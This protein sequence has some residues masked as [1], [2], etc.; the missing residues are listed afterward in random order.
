M[1]ERLIKEEAILNRFIRINEYAESEYTES[2]N[3]LI[4]TSSES[5]SYRLN[6][7]DY[8]RENKVVFYTLDF[9]IKN[10]DKI[11]DLIVQNIYIVKT[12]EGCPYL[13]RGELK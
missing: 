8:V 11:N 5:S 13:L 3:I 2:E 10:K 1:V 9:S 6:K 7:T 4:K 12:I